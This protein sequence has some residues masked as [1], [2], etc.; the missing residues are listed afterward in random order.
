MRKP[1]ICLMLMLSAAFTAYSQSSSVKG[2]VT[3]SIDKKNLVNT[4]ISLLRES[5]SVL[6]KFTRADKEGQFVLNGLKEGK[7]ILMATHPYLGDFFDKV[8]VKA[9]SVTDL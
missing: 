5:D 7:F 1:V 6:V 4:T 3:D 2:I 8:D 9:G